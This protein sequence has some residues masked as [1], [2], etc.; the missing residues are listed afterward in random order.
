LIRKISPLSQISGIVD[1]HA[2]SDK[3]LSW[4]HTPEQLLS[5][6]RECGIVRSVLTSY[7][8]LP[9]EADS[10]A[11][12]RFESVLKQHKEFIGFLRLNP[13]DFMAETLLA[14][15][16]NEKLIFGLK[17]NPMTSPVSPYSIN[18]L[19]LVAVSAGLGLPVLFHTGD[20]PF[21]HPLQIER[22]A[23]SCPEAT[24]ILGHMGGFF[25]V[26]EAIRVAKRNRNVY[27]ESSVMPYP[28]LIQIAVRS[29]GAKRV[30][31][32]SD[33]PGVHSRVEIQKILSSGLSPAEQ[34]AV[35][36]TSFLKII[37]SA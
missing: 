31:F 9:S 22:V 3:K 1:A 19:K 33:A 37:G 23:R 21:S 29:L 30:F 36:T 2:H 32:G 13:N 10:E 27:L 25:Y 34:E 11:I 15:M 35:L 17:L 14:R 6:M 26:E 24:I 12:I 8:D 28:K 20:D 18:T 16:A 7:W 4:H 5:M